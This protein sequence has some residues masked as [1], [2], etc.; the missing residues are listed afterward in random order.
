[1]S[2]LL[3]RF[4]ELLEAYERNYTSTGKKVSCVLLYSWKLPCADELIELFS[5]QNMTVI[6]VY[7]T[8]RSLTV[9]STLRRQKF[10]IIQCQS[11][12]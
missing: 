4:D 11:V 8:E 1:M 3:E 10:K 6:I 7:S 5:N 9:L 2:I 12:P